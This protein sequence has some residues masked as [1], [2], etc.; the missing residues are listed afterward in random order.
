MVW[1]NYLAPLG[2][3]IG[4][5]RFS[6]RRRQKIGFWGQDRIH[7]VYSGFVRFSPTTK[8]TKSILRKGGPWNRP[9]FFFAGGKVIRSHFRSKP[10]LRVKKCVLR[11]L[12]DQKPY[13]YQGLFGRAPKIED[14]TE[15]NDTRR[16]LR[17]ALL[18]RHFFLAKLRVRK[19]SEP[20]KR[21]LGK[22]GFITGP[23]QGS[24]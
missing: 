20:Q 10:N 22:R 13:F 18:P 6:R 19:G 1:D 2:W 24:D 15:N 14:K 12:C 4:N 16:L 21:Y 7:Y 5:S 23:W 8:N 17:T 11:R 3:N 9:V